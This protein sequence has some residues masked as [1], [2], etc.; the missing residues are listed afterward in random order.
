[1]PRQKIDYIHNNPVQRGYVEHLAHWR[2][3]SARDYLTGEE[4]LLPVF[5]QWE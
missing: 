2:Y 5:R 3:S 1:M 4:G